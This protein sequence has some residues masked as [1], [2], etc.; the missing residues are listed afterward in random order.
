MIAS[1]AVRANRLT[2]PVNGAEQRRFA[3]ARRLASM[4]A[5]SFSPTSPCLEARRHDA[6]HA[7]RRQRS[8]ALAGQGVA[9][10]EL[11]AVD[12]H[13][14]R[15]NRALGFLDWRQAEF[16]AA[17]LSARNG[18]LR[19]EATISPMIETAISAGLTAPMS[20]PI[21]AWIRASAAS[22]KPLGPHALDPLGVRL[23]RAERADVEAIG[24]E[25]DHRAP[26][27]RSWGR[28]SGGRPR[29]SGRAAPRR[30]PR[31]AIWRRSECRE[32]GPAS[33][34]RCADR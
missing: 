31:P 20:S 34:R 33:R 32:S 6:R 30:A 13:P 21:G 23:S 29:Y 28:G 12:P 10:L 16:H 1:P 25:R 7:R 26:G 11:G 27:R 9:L 19:N 5:A 2:R 24:F 3:P 14:V 8:P 18:F 15:E 22:S 17:A 4:S